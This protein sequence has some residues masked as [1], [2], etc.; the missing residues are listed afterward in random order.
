MHWLAHLNAHP[1]SHI[2]FPWIGIKKGND[3]KAI[4]QGI[5]LGQ[6]LE[7]GPLGNID[8]DDSETE[9]RGHRLT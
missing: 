1:E 2:V 4:G 3:G 7:V 8:P 5:F 9:I 6:H